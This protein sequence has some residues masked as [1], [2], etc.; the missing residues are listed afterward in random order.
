MFL[1]SIPVWSEMWQV[2][3]DP[4][5]FPEGHEIAEHVRI[6]YVVVVEGTVRLRPKEVVNSRMATGAVEVRFQNL[7]FM[8]GLVLI[9]RS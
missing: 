2:T 9:A 8:N 4:V 3:S 6:E 7:Q 5:N 1:L